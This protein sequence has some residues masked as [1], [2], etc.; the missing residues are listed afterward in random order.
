MGSSANPYPSGT[1]LLDH[2]H[3]L[4]RR[5]PL[6]LALL[7]LELDGISTDT[8]LMAEVL[9][10]ALSDR[11]AR[12]AARAVA[13]DVLHADT[14]AMPSTLRDVA[15]TANK[16]FEPGGEI[17]TLLFSRGIHIILAHRVAHSLW[18]AGR[19]DLSLAVKTTFSRVFS[20]DLHP[21][22]IF[23]SGIWLDH[24][25]GFVVGETAVIEDDVSIW[26]GVTLGSKLKDA[27]AKRHPQIRRGATLCAN[28]TV[29]GSIE[30]GEGSVIAAGAVVLTDVA[31]FS[32]VAG[33]P[34][35]PKLRSERSFSGI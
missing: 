15:I 29:L 23:G 6:A 33:V 30:V 4:H 12:G 17:A 14:E 22:A 3:D 21:G 26:H 31:P 7:G 10:S 35:R 9:A 32:T 8:D 24:G 25:V 5:E 18:K 20:I 13:K 1:R 2:A 16:N 19:R 34:A 27:G 11:S 28:A